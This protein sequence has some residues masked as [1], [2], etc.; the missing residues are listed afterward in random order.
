LGTNAQPF[1]L[2]TLQGFDSVIEKTVTRAATNTGVSYVPFRNA[3][4]ERLQAVTGLI[5]VKTLTPEARQVITSLRT[6]PSP[7]IASAAA[8][9]LT[10]RAPLGD[11]PRAN[12]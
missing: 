4:L 5:H 10:R 9:V 1:L 2:A 8:Y 6:N 11:P 12:P 7:D 3:D